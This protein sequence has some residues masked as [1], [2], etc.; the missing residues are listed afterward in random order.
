MT[1][2]IVIAKL[3]R[4]EELSDLTKHLLSLP[5]VERTN[6]HVVLNTIKEDLR[7]I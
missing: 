5:H 2:A 1:D 4:R 3:K 7:V 6:T